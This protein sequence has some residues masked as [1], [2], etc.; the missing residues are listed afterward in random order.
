MNLQHTCSSPV[1][2]VGLYSE[3]F[4]CLL[5]TALKWRKPSD[6]Q[7]MQ[8][9]RTCGYSCYAVKKIHTIA[10][11]A[12]TFPVREKLYKTQKCSVWTFIRGQNSCSLPRLRNKAFEKGSTSWRSTYK[13]VSALN[14]TL[15]C[16]NP[17]FPHE[18]ALCETSE[19]TLCI[20]FTQIKE[21]KSAQYIPVAY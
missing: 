11:C 2:W 21:E 16:P 7:L 14:C 18:Q 5:F 1:L 15:I 20:T 9:Y 10:Y 19:V 17:E 3:L 12:S 8:C 4:K 13:V 6:T